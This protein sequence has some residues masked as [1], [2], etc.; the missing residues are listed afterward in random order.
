VIIYYF[1]SMVMDFFSLMIGAVNI[2]ALPL[3]F[4]T[5]LAF[6]TSFV[7]SGTQFLTYLLGLPLYLTCL[8]VIPA[9]YALE[10]IVNLTLFT[11][12]KLPFLNIR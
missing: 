3:E 6:I 12:G 5:A 8:A 2:P 10:F 4:M 1:F 9:V 11:L 7:T